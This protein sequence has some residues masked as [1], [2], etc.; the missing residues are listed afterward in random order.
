MLPIA[1]VNVLDHAFALIA[2]GKVDID[3][4]P[5]AALFGKEALEEQIHADGID[6]RDAERVTDSAVGGGPAAL[7]QNP[8]FF[9]ETH[10][11]PD[12]QEIAAEFQ[13]VD[14][15]QLTFDLL[16]RAIVIR[17]VPAARAFIGQLPQIR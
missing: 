6:R 1:L 5:F 2:A 13:L 12:D 9:G 15:L 14:E 10:K 16:P 8:L 7:A 3:V 17:L 4:R 11:I